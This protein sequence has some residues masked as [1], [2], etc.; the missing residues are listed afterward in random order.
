MQADHQPL[1]GDAFARLLEANLAALRAYARGL[2]GNDTQADDLVQDT[3]LKA[4]EHL[5]TYDPSRPVKPWLFSILRNEFLRDVRRSWRR[6]DLTDT[7]SD[8]ELTAADTLGA[9]VDAHLMVDLLA[10]L[11]VELRDSVSLVLGLGL[12]YEEAAEVCGVPPGTVKSRVSRG[13][14]ALVDAFAKRETAT[15]RPPLRHAPEA[16]RLR[17]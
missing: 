9:Q 8:R 13:R 4:F 14:A 6:L 7:I 5:H 12:T 1:S 10:T 3:F 11:P 16:R 2:C 15:T 17:A